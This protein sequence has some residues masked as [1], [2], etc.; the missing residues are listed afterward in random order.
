MPEGACDQVAVILN[1]LRDVV[2]PCSIA[3]GMPISLPDMG[4]IKSLR[5]LDGTAIIVLRVTSP[6]CMQVGNIIAG[7]EARLSRVAGIT[8]VV[9]T[10]DPG[11]DWTPEMMASELRRGRQIA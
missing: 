5:V 6:L 8:T 9:C 3:T 10:I 4:L 7:V 11:A 1:A 2:D